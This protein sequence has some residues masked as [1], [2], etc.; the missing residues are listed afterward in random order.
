MNIY[1][2]KLDIL[3]IKYVTRYNDSTNYKVKRLLAEIIEHLKEAKNKDGKF[4]LKLY[5]NYDAKCF[6]YGQQREKLLCSI[7]H[8]FKKEMEN[9]FYLRK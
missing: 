7:C 2:Q 5:T 9:V 6:S 4:I 3:I 8:T 1:E